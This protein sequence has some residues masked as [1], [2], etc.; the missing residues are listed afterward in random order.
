MIG[1]ILKYYIPIGIPLIIIIYF[2]SEFSLGWTLFFGL[3]ITIGFI[4]YYYYLW[5][6]SWLLIGNQKITLYVRDG[7]FSQYSMNIRYRNI[8]D[9]A[10]S[11]N[12]IF[13]Y[14][15][16]YGTFFARS[17]GAEG[18][19][20]AKFVPKVGKVYALVNAL[21][22]YSDDDR[23]TIKTIEELHSHHITREFPID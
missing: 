2:L 13:S 23:E 20:T 6:L 12:N 18:D 9:S 8:R 1:K 4:G 3:V 19:F 22:R 16:K 21:T 15:F 14:L 5:S 17:S 10:C 11:K 7:I